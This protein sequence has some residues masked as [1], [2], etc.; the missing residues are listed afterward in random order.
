MIRRMADRLV[1]VDLLTPATTLLAYQV[2]KRLDGVAKA[3]VATRLAAVQ[4][5]D[6]K[7]GDA[8]ATLRDSEITG[9]P[10]DVIH[11]RLILEAR[12]FAALKQY[13]NALDLIAA[14][15]AADTRQVRADIYWESGNWA[16]AGQKI[17]EMLNARA[18]DAPFT[19]AD[20]MDLMRA[21]VAYSLANDEKSLERLGI[22]WMPKLKGTPDAT[23]FAVLIQPIDMHGLAFRD[24]AAKIASVDTLKGFMRDFQKK[25]AA[26][27]K[28]S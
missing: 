4:V 8:I 11:A 28:A 2:E 21:A 24:A 20:R 18:A 3:Q 9:L 26:P 15:D 13:D 14:D 6:A 10:D 25:F 16:V 5:M 22:A 7:P 12:A 27:A 17:E 19:A 1:A 23:L